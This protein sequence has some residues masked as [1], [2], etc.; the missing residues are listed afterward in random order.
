VHHERHFT[1]DQ[2]REQLPWVT[3]RLATLR[4]AH[5]RLTDE[6]ARHALAGGASGNGGGA[7][8]KQVGEAFLEIQTSVAAFD[9]RG[10]LLRDLDRGL[11]DFPSLREGR[12]VYLCWVAGEADIAYWHELDDGF[13]GRQPL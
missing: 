3:D 6:E 5:A 1:L 7:A 11:V 2:A 13:P 8:G 4:D 9:A 12:E 10:I